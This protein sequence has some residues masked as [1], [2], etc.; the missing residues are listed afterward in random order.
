MRTVGI[1]LF[2][3]SVF[4]AQAS[5]ATIT[6]NDTMLGSNEVPANASPATGSATVVL[7][8]TT[9]MLSVIISFSGLF[10]GP[11][12][13][14]HI[15]CCAAAGTNAAVAVPFPGFPNATSGTYSNTFDLTMSATY[16]SAFLTASGGTAADA[17]AAL[18]A[19]L[20]SGLAYT[21]IHTPD[22]PGGE[23]RGQLAT[24]VPEPTTIVLSGAALFLAAA[25]R[26]RNRP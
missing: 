5:A 15:H 12:E 13:A 9:N 3:A 18:I 6:Y 11:A 20:N 7:D 23:I 25:L 21:N 26:R 17:E 10:G 2:S 16:N 1:L 24:G 4:A 22:F 14:S 19:G 8:T